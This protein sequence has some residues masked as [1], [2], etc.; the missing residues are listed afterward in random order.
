[1]KSVRSLTVREI[2][3]SLLIAVGI[4]I[5]VGTLTALWKNPFFTRMTP[6]SGYELFLLFFESILMG[7]YFGVKRTACAPKTSG[8]GSV[9][10]FLGIACPVCNKILLL[11]FGAGFLL[12]YFEPVRLYVGLLGIGLLFFALKQKLSLPA[13]T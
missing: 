1:M 3:V 7:L 12:T 9:L 6:T 4:F 10:G 11:I 2:S 5:L 13:Y 8:T